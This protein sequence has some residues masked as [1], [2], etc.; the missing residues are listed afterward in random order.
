MVI[1]IDGVSGCS[2][3]AARITDVSRSRGIV[4]SENFGRQPD[5]NTVSNTFSARWIV[6]CLYFFF[7]HKSIIRS[8]N[9]S[10]KEDEM[11]L[12]LGEAL[13]A[14]LILRFVLF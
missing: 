3:F 4:S 1:L 11:N 2:T 8:A 10:R 7:W 5:S 9:S 12:V 6:S 14:E 13:L